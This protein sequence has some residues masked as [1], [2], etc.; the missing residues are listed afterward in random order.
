M[1]ISITIN[2]VRHEITILPSSLTVQL[3]SNGFHVTLGRREV[4]SACISQ[5]LWSI[6]LLPFWIELAFASLS[7]SVQLCPSLITIKNI[8]E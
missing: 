5:E 8:E 2:N 4:N 7:K 3:H 6:E 1:Y